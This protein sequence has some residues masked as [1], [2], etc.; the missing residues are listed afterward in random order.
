MPN[1]PEA[2]D[3]T[4]IQLDLAQTATFDIGPDDKMHITAK[5]ASSGWGQAVLVHEYSVLA[6]S[7]A[8]PPLN[9]LHP[10]VYSDINQDLD[11]FGDVPNTKEKR[12]GYIVTAWAWYGAPVNQ[13]RQVP[14]IEQNAL[15]G[16]AVASF[17]EAN[18]NPKL[19]PGP[20]GNVKVFY[21]VVPR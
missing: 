18:P 1:W 7:T 9:I 2:P 19:A 12:Q 10:A 8:N 13:W 21:G 20:G 14:K 15:P 6:P 3:I 11:C 4:S 17:L 5:F 16:G